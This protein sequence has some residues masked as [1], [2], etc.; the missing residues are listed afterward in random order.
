MFFVSQMRIKIDTPL[1]YTR[2]KYT[3]LIFP[4]RNAFQ[5]YLKL[6]AHKILTAME[7]CFKS[8][9]AFEN[10]ICILKRKLKGFCFVFLKLHMNFRLNVIEK[11]NREDLNVMLTC[12]VLI[13]KHNVNFKIKIRGIISEYLFYFLEHEYLCWSKNKLYLISTHMKWTCIL[14]VN[15]VTQAWSNTYSHALFNAL[16]GKVSQLAS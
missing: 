7:L 11:L 2:W 6:H 14:G 4:P 12:L 9:G 13:H 15:T 10:K 5:P 3:A 16:H 8:S 1:T